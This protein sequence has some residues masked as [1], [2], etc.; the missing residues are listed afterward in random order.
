MKRP[1]ATPQLRQLGETLLEV[2]AR[3]ETL[4][5]GL[6]TLARSQNA[7]RYNVPG[8]WVRVHTAHDMVSTVLTVIPIRWAI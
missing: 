6:L 7:I 5:D 8:G 2:N 3:H 1:D 4:V